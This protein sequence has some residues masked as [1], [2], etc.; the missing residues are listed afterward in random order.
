M[1]ALPAFE[2]LPR[3]LSADRAGDTRVRPLRGTRTIRLANVAA[4][5]RFDTAVPDDGC[6][7]LMPARTAIVGREGVYLARAL[8]A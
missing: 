6:T 8:P 3:D 1:S 2:V 7:V 4:N 5:E